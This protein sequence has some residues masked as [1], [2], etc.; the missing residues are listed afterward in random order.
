M[1]DSFLRDQHFGLQLHRKSGILIFGYRLHRIHRLDRHCQINQSQHRKVHSLSYCT[2]HS[3]M[4]LLRQ[5]WPMLGVQ[6]H[7]KLPLRR[8]HFL[9]L[10]CSRFL[11]RLDQRFYQHSGALQ[12]LDCWLPT[13]RISFGLLL[14]RCVGQLLTS[15][16]FLRGYSILLPR[17][18]VYSSCLYP[19]RM[20]PMRFQHYLHQMLSLQQLHPQQLHADLWVRCCGAVH[21]PFS[22]RL[23]LP[24]W[25]LHLF[26]QYLWT[27]AFV[28]SQWQRMCNLQLRPTKQ[29]R[30]MWRFRIFLVR[31]QQPCF[32]SLHGRLLLRRTFMSSMQHITFRI[33]LHLR[34]I[35]PLPQL[36]HELHSFQRRL[37]M[38]A[39]VLP[40]RRINLLQLR[41][42]LSPLQRR[43]FM[44]SLRHW[45]QLYKYKWG[46]YVYR[47]HVPERYCLSGLWVD[48]GMSGLHQHG[49]YRVRS[50][51]W[52]QPQHHHLS[53]SMR[54]WVFHQQY[55]CLWEMLSFGLPALRFLNLVP[56][57]RPFL[58]AQLDRRLLGSVRRRSPLY[59][60]VRRQ[61]HDQWRRM[62]RYLSGINWLHLCG[63]NNLDI[64]WML[65]FWH[66][67]NY[68]T[69]YYQ[70]PQN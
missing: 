16:R 22:R 3:G 7:S 66:S 60:R 4:H 36:W 54:L 26:Q 10:G 33:L 1:H 63:R 35:A 25:L 61:Q 2:S 70:R 65:I 42:R 32:M 15:Q 34:R 5:F 47:R 11:P 14:L 55:G 17:Q 46:L 57:M 48:A 51:L 37:Q 67:Y 39:S 29:L 13:L 41:C 23:H 68:C 64:I 58:L 53:L 62:Q 59:F 43:S 45:Q 31:S 30:P 28:S 6:H 50:Y 24:D 27:Y 9:L 44:H 18:L 20:L 49:M 21:A 8:C 56:L 12:L 69:F 38:S 52:I 19:N 40:I